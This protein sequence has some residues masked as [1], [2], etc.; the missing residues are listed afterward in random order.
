MD[1]KIKFK[2]CFSFSFCFPGT[3]CSRMGDDIKAVDYLNKA[4]ALVKDTA[5]E[6]LSTFLVN[7]GKITKSIGYINE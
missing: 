7:L 2:S 3:V 1:N 4:V 6:N 5:S